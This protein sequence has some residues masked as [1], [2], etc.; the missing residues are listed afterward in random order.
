MGRTERFV[1]PRAERRTHPRRYR[2]RAS[3]GTNVEDE[4]GGTTYRQQ[5][6]SLLGDMLFV[7][8]QGEWL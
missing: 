7:E 2:G 4:A 1:Q 5:P 6:V 3:D 8:G